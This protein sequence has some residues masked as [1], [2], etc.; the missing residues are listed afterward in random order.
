MLLWWTD[1]PSTSSE[2]VRS[3]TLGDHANHGTGTTIIS[4]LYLDFGVFYVFIGMAILG[5]IW[6]LIKNRAQRFPL[7]HDYVMMYL[8]AVTSL[9]QCGR[10]GLPMPIRFIGWMLILL[11]IAR[12]LS[13][14]PLTL[15]RQQH[16]RSKARELYGDS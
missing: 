1:A 7:S 5:L 10:Y 15:R 11:I 13:K 16:R 4:D 14:N 8:I 6:G 9:A 12:L 3:F 2:I